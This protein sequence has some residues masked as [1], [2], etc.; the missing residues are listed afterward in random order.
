MK[1]ISTFN[2]F[3]SKLDLLLREAEKQDNPGWWLYKNDARTPAFMLEGLARLYKQVEDE[4]KGIK[5]I[6]EDFKLLEDAIGS[7]DYYDNL[8][9]D[10][11]KIPSVDKKYST[12]LRNR[13]DDKV[14]ELN[15]LLSNR[16]WTGH[17]ENRIMRCQEKLKKVKW[18]DEREDINGFRKYYREEISEI[19]DFIDSRNGVFTK[20]EEEVHEFRRKIRWLSIYPRALNGAIQLSGSIEDKPELQNYFTQEIIQSPYNTMPLPEGRKEILY[21]SKPDFF[22]LSWMIAAIGKLKDQGLNIL[23]LAEAITSLDDIDEEQAIK[24]AIIQADSQEGALE[25]ILRNSSELIKAY[26]KTNSLRHLPA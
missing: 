21:L 6:K 12:Y 5:K 2:F 17:K 14:S 1:G 23:G 19:N 13:S 22:A 18:N 25:E 10:L 4:E 24:K 9:N 16:K 26:R 3:L 15:S 11:G 8:A 20:M 7:I